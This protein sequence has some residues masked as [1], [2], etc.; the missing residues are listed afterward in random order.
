MPHPY[1][2]E[3]F[4]LCTTLLSINKVNSNSTPQ[5]ADLYGENDPVLIHSTGTC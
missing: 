4:S 5:T 3:A 2:N 1:N